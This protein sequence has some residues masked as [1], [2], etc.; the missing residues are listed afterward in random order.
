[1]THDL[2]FRGSRDHLIPHWPFPVD[3]LLEQGSI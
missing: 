2:T 1:M 3:G